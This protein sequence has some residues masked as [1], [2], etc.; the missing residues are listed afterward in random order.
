[1]P[2]SGWQRQHAVC[3]STNQPQGKGASPF[4]PMD[5]RALRRTSHQRSLSPSVNDF[6]GADGE[7]HTWWV[8][9]TMVGLE[10]KPCRIAKGEGRGKG[11]GRTGYSS[12]NTACIRPLGG[13]PFSPRLGAFLPPPSPESSEAFLRAPR[14]RAPNGL[15][16]EGAAAMWPAPLALAA[17]LSSL[18]KVSR[19]SLPNVPA[20][21][22][23]SVERRS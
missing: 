10:P 1:M 18:P 19:S 5:P 16:W 20:P 11:Q 21:R 6:V 8:C 2:Y 3:G 4:G 14:L 9:M 7:R 12:R 22:I 15:S 13:R 17:W 23:K